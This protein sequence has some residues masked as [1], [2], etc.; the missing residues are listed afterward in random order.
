[1]SPFFSRPEHVPIP[2]WQAKVPGRWVN[3]G[4]LRVG[5]VLY[6]KSGTLAPIEELTLREVRET[7]YNFQVEELESYA[8]G[9]GAVLVHNT[10]GDSG[11]EG[12]PPV[13]PAQSS[14][15]SP[16]TPRDIARRQGNELVQEYRQEGRGT[17]AGRSDGH[18]IP[19]QQAGAELIRR[20]NKLPKNDPLRAALKTEGKRLIERGKAISHK[21]GR[22]GC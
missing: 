4:D 2:P 15:P 9:T 17:T 22:R 3:A 18:G 14:Q 7:V 1:M 16:E 12:I 19:F 21:G 20:A 5:D 10:S 8:V 11:I 6:L 13:P